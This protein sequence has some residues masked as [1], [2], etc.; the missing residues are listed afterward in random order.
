MGDNAIQTAYLQA[1][2]RVLNQ[3]IADCFFKVIKKIAKRLF[4]YTHLGI[5]FFKPN[6]LSSA[7]KAI[8]PSAKTHNQLKMR[9]VQVQCKQWDIC[10]ECHDFNSITLFS[11]IAA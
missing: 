8:G 4:S 1:V 9:Q 6:Q 11:W 5:C 3:G 7:S 2:A 10:H